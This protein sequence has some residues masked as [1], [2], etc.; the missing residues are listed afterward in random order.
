M[1][2]KRCA[3]QETPRLLLGRVA[4]GNGAHGVLANAARQHPSK[5][6]GCHGHVAGACGSGL[7]REKKIA[8]GAN[9]GGPRQQ[10]ASDMSVLLRQA[11]TV[12]SALGCT[13]VQRGQRLPSHAGGD[14]P[15]A[16]NGMASARLQCALSLESAFARVPAA[17]LEP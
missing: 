7:G 11:S 10:T 6:D 12:P 2:Q 3:R 16:R 1:C 17:T 5:L 9:R 4:R 8:Q 14:A 15:K 13:R